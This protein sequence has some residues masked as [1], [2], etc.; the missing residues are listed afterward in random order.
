[1]SV[2]RGFARSARGLI[3]PG[4]G[5]ALLTM[6]A[7]HVTAQCQPVWS[8]LQGGGSGSVEALAA[9]DPDGPG[10]APKRLVAG[11][12]LWAIGASRV[13]LIGQ[14]DGAAWAPVASGLTPTTPLNGWV[15]SLLPVSPD[16]ASPIQPGLY[17]GGRFNGAG[18]VPV[19]NLARW[20]GIDWF[21]VGGGVI[22][23][24]PNIATYVI[25]TRLFDEDGPGPGAPAL[26][27]GGAFDRAGAVPID[28]L[29]RWNGQNWSQVG[30]PLTS[31]VPNTRPTVSALEVFDDDGPGPRP[32]ALYVGGGFLYAGGTL[33]RHIA[34]WDG[35]SW[36]LLGEGIS[37][38]PVKSLC[39]FDED[40]PGP[41]K[42]ALFVGGV[43]AFA[44]GQPLPYLARWD[45][46]KWTSVGGGINSTVLA[47]TVYDDDGPG[48]RPPAL[49]A[50]GFF[51]H[52]GATEVNRIAR[53]D[54]QS[55]SPLGSGVSGYGV[56]TQ[57]MSLAVFDEDGPGPN[58]GGLYVGGLFYYAGGVWGKHVA[59]WGCPIPVCYSNCNGDA[60]RSG[61]GLLNIADFGCFQN[62]FAL[63]TPYADCNQDG[64]NTIADFAC[65]QTRFANGCP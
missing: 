4:V 18:P 29:A 57:V 51:T 45:G 2:A 60:A 49:Y 46:Q 58:P 37:S 40:G 15:Q 24:V 42:P 34:R 35:V 19:S 25:A 5:V 28:A 61:G 7:P 36:E 55:W 21:D 1:M 52:V 62:A 38:G 59:R 22:S 54:G 47:M 20:D 9:F 53:W 65:F 14:W 6:G 33:V 63:L 41:M 44:G 13:L 11:G 64:V 39:V 8:G 31:G 12:G 26:F 56:G 16:P 30:G 3:G 43:F 23:S 48:P 10:G 27:V 50:G 17:A 32:P